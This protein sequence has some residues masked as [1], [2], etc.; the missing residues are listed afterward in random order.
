MNIIVVENLV[1]KY[2]SLTAV[3]QISF[4]VKAG[5]IFGL[6]G[7]NGAGKT[8]TVECIIGLMKFDEGFVEILSLNPITDNKKLYK[9]IGVQLQETSY[10]DK[11]KVK[12]LCELFTIMYEKPL[13]YHRLL[14][15]FGLIDKTNTNVNQLS[16]GERQKIAIILALIA[17]PQV[18]ILDELTT[19]LDP[20]SRREMWECIKNL[21]RE[22]RTVFMTTH[23]M[24]E[25]AY[26]C[27][28]IGIMNKGKLIAIDSVEG[29]IDK[30]D[31]D[32]TISFETEDDVFHIIKD[33]LNKKINKIE[34]NNTKVKIY[35]KS[36][37]VLTDLIILLRDKKINYRKIDIKRPTLED[38]Y[39]KLVGKEKETEGNATI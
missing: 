21:K 17:N 18:I 15:Q 7:P 3:N 12:E 11:I 23:Y 35:T 34:I 10:Q 27:D 24:E 2:K 1:K 38:A 16:G 28:Q 37:D 19:G 29:I 30:A 26:L 9:E 33:E 25:A 20:K 22:G 39:L 14:E 31:I 32:I 6:L 36:E 4:S 13:D 5:S 8:T